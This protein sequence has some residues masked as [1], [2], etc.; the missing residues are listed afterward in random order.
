MGTPQGGVISPLLANVALHG[1]ENR[2]KQFA[3]SLPGNKQANSKTLTFVRYA[4]DFVVLHP[5]R[6]II[7]KAKN[8]LTDWLTKIGLEISEAKTKVTHTSEGFDFL[9]FNIRQYKVGKHSSGKNGHGKT[10]GHKTLIKPAKEKVLKHYRNMAEIINSYNVAPQAALVKKLNPIIRGWA[11]YYSTV[12]SKETFS[13][14]DYLT[15]VRL[16]RW[17]KRR[18]PN[19]N[20]NYAINKYFK[21]VE[22][23][24]WVF[25]DKSSTLT[26]HADTPIIRHIKVKDRKSPYDGDMAYWASRLGKH[27]ELSNRVSKL[28]KVQKGKCNHCGLTFR[29]GDIWE[30]DHITPRN[31]GGKD[32]YNNLQLLHRHCHDVKTA[33]DIARWM[34]L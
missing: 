3:E 34:Y 9:G 17:C 13:K 25:G 33:N 24:N 6:R 2:L 21:T 28:L 11:N 29:D 19:K 7:E 22:D 10:L 26:S 23:R 8:I 31:Q 5:D 27:P 12:V 32:V 14:L 30:V 15:W 16:E 4:D 18:H 1:M 20:A